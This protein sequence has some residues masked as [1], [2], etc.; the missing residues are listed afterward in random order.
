MDVI[1]GDFRLREHEREVIG[2][3]GRVELSGRAFELLRAF[4]ARPDTLLDK[5]QLFAAA[6]PDVIVEDN[7]LQVHISALR[8]A[9]GPGLIGTVHGRGYRYVGPVPSEAAGAVATPMPAAVT[10]TGNIDRYRSDC[11]ARESEL[12]AVAALITDHR[13]VTIVGPGGVGKTTL[14]VAVAS[15]A[16]RPQ[17]GTWMIDL[18][19]IDNGDAIASTLIQ[20]LGVHFRAGSEATDSIVEHLRRTGDSLLVFDNCEHLQPDAARFID[21]LMKQIPSLRILATSQVPLG[22]AEERLFRLL[23]FT[24]AGGGEIGS[25]SERFFSYCL[26]RFGDSLT[27]AERPVAARLAARLDGVALALKMAAARSS[28]IGLETVD[29]QLEA[30][31][32]NLAAD[33][34]TSLP[35]HRSL[36][37]SLAWSYELLS[38]EDQ[39]VLRAL[40]VFH[41]SFS[42]AA[43]NA[44]AGEGGGARVAELVRRSLVV[45]DGVDRSRYRLLDSTRRF[46]LDLLTATDELLAARELHLAFMTKLFADSFERWEVVPDDIWRAT[47]RPDGDNLRAA[48][49]FAKLRPQSQGYVELASGTSRYFVEEH[50]GAE[51]LAVIEAGMALASNASPRA[52]AH[53]GAALGDI[54]RFNAMDIRSAEGLRP[55]IAW[56]RTSTDVTRYHQ[57]LVL[58]AMSTIFFG[59]KA[60]AERFVV[61]LNE[62]L[63]AMGVS[64]TK[65]WALVCLGTH[66]WVRGEREAGLARV[67]AGFAMHRET[68]NLRGLFRSATTFIETAHKEGDT[69]L[70]LSIA[71]AIEPDLRVHGSRLQLANH[72]SNIAA[73][74]FWVGDSSG[75]APYHSEAMLL[76]P[77]DESYWHVCMLQ[78]ESEQLHWEG[79]HADAALL[80]GIVDWRILAWPDGRQS[81]EQMQRDK[82]GRL[83]G[84]VLGKVE[85]ER[86]L[87]QGKSLDLV[88]AEQLTAEGRRAPTAG[89]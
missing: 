70:A 42:L 75:A 35:R 80:L 78:N 40:G 16:D 17:G 69:A 49:D 59:S 6:W 37:A 87:A 29:Q 71:E 46:A 33:W 3:A 23:P 31:L 20:S 26:E 36:M 76:S 7:T 4:L 11:V 2:P 34:D 19:A 41:G 51:G 68:G 43:V 84:D 63:P 12:A 82:L 61:E 66:L 64:K 10:P 79:K 44:I 54:C 60:D 32:A 14:A 83:L 21:A 55:A 85:F 9:L 77:R 18:A 52:A 47:Y 15:Q 72:L 62:Q 30:Q 8:K 22:L 86:L 45:R 73:Y 28:S 48:L 81:T 50:L 39:R 1:F 53:I 27:E 67:R 25:P 56:L 57:S 5:D 74:R 24:V 88:D 13:L 89:Q 65:A 58:I 38:P